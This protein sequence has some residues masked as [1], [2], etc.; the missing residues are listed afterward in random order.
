MADSAAELEASL[1]PSSVP[2]K[3][4]HIAHDNE[5]EG[6][7]TKKKPESGAHGL[8]QEVMSALTQIFKDL[9]ASKDGEKKADGDSRDSQSTS[10]STSPSMVPEIRK[11]DFEHFKN[12]F[13]EEDGQ[14]IVEALV[15][16]SNLA[17]AVRVE[18]FRRNG[19]RVAPEAA[20]E[21][22]TAN[23]TMFPPD[24]TIQRV[25]IQS[26]AILNYLAKS[27]AE[28]SELTDTRT[29]LYPFRPLIHSYESMCQVLRLLT[30]H[31]TDFTDTTT[32]K[33]DQEPKTHDSG[34]LGEPKGVGPEGGAN[35][36]DST[37]VGNDALGSDAPT[38]MTL[39]PGF[40]TAEAL[41]EIKAY[42]T[43][44]GNDLLPL[45]DKYSGVSRQTVSFDDLWLLFSP[46]EYVVVPTGPQSIW[47][48]ERNI[49]RGEF[50][51]T[52]H[53]NWLG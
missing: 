45:L 40:D 30:Q 21:S 20:L 31:C 25:R 6:T 37:A 52:L 38:I 24:S 1:T 23:I 4:E 26:K 16:G 28:A 5:H 39:D 8:R 18:A 42:V 46:G 48:R 50:T 51:C 36:N 17:Q 10:Q 34:P 53:S 9:N 14:Y 3:Q 49:F 41:A 29:F 2:T 32:E 15:A 19:I 11:V 47:K 44:V 43:F 27:L 33:H 12:R 35:R 22:G 13:K 7:T